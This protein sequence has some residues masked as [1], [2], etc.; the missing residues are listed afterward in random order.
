MA[1]HEAT[2]T[3]PAGCTL[4]ISHASTDDKDVR[5][6]SVRLSADHSVP[7]GKRIEQIRRLLG[8]W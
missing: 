8:S 1:A 2:V 7:E 3:L 6:A 5:D 4:E